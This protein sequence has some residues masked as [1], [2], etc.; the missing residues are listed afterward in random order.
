MTQ[1]PQRTSKNSPRH[2][3]FSRTPRSVKG[4]IS[5]VM[6]AKMTTTQ[7]SGSI[8]MSTTE[9]CILRSQRRNTRHSP[10]NTRTQKRSKKTYWPSTKITMETSLGFLNA[11]CVVKMT[12][13]LASSNSSRNTSNSKSSRRQK[14]SS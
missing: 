3:K 4:T 11:S 10:V 13:S 6:T 12:T 1:K 9:L 8:A 5:S 7:L 2:T 14:L